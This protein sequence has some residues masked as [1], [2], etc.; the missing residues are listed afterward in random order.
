MKNVIISTIFVGAFFIF[1]DLSYRFNNS[2]NNSEQANKSLNVVPF[3]QHP[4]LT[5]AFRER[6]N[7]AFNPYRQEPKSIIADQL[8]GLTRAEQLAQEG[9]LIDFFTEGFRYRLLAI[10]EP[11]GMQ[12]ALYVPIAILKGDNLNNPQE[13]PEIK[14][15]Y[16]GS[17]FSGYQVRIQGTKHIKLIQQQ[18]T[19]SLHMYK[20]KSQS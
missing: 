19:I 10:I 6:L 20:P 14:R 16:H 12:Q 13:D 8:Q 1:L 2:T 18:K 3:I 15:V 17:I 9:D 5:T 4:Q 7:N 11:E